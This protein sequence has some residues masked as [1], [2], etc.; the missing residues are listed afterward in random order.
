[1]GI[2]RHLSVANLCQSLFTMTT[3]IIKYADRQI[4]TLLAQHSNS[5]E[6]VQALLNGCLAF[7]TPLLLQ[8]SKVILIIMKQ[9]FCKV[10]IICFC[11]WAVQYRCI[12]SRRIVFGYKNLNSLDFW[13][14]FFAFFL[15]SF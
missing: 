13:A 11:F 10:F 3:I 14:C 1:M 6:S 2:D 8:T 5:L 12:H 7:V 15:Q 4:F 9:L